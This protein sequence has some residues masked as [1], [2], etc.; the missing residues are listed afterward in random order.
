MATI[1][2]LAELSRMLS[3]LLVQAPYLLVETNKETNN[4]QTV[5]RLGGGGHNLRTI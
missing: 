1:K 4:Y 3:D 2:K 5:T